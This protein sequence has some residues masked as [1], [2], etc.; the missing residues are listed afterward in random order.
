MLTLPAAEIHWWSVTPE[1]SECRVVINN[2]FTRISDI[3]TVFTS[4]DRK[5]FLCFIRLN[6]KDIINRGNACTY[7]NWTKTRSWYCTLM[8]W[9]ALSDTKVF[10]LCTHYFLP[11]K[12]HWLIPVVGII[13][14][15]FLLSV[16]F[17]VSVNKYEMPM[18]FLH[19][20]DGP[21]VWFPS[22]LFH[23]PEF[24]LKVLKFIS[25]P[26]CLY[27]R[28]GLLL[29]HGRQFMQTPAP[30]LP[31]HHHSCPPAN[32][33]SVNTRLESHMLEYPVVEPQELRQMVTLPGF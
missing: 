13:L 1:F 3:A 15:K 11:F 8:H 6:L 32:R 16:D 4:K 20:P 9:W 21:S 10:P 28:K 22:P 24:L 2:A 14:T 7:G 29:H 5:S 25:I 19:T 18:F 31:Q 27:Y 33:V 30:T 12:D 26:E 17:A 23:S